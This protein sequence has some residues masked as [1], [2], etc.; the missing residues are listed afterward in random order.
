MLVSLYHVDTNPE[1]AFHNVHAYYD[2]FVI[3]N[4]GPVKAV[5]MVMN[6]QGLSAAGT[7]SKQPLNPD[8]L[9]SVARV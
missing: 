6:P 5:K 3:N 7:G 1:I 2:K 9:Q 8:R 4:A